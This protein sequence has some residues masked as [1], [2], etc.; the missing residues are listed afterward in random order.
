MEMHQAIHKADCGMVAV[1]LPLTDLDHSLPRPTSQVKS[2]KMDSQSLHCFLAGPDSKEY[3]AYSVLT[4]APS[5]A[6]TLLKPFLTLSKIACHIFLH[7]QL[8]P[9]EQIPTNTL[10]FRLQMCFMQSWGCEQV[11]IR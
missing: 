3:D 6:Q 9:L 10:G 1:S 7:L 8:F 4:K 5:R 2:L 11:G